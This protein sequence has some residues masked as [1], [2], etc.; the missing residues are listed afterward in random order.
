M[1]DSILFTPVRAGAVTLPNRLVMAPLT[2][3]RAL[4]GNVPN[5]LA[6][7]YY[8]QRATAGL[9]VAEATQVTPEG[10]GYPDTPGIHSDAQVEGWKSIVEAVHAAGGRIYLQLWHVGRVSHPLYQPAGALPVSASAI[11]IKGQL[12]THEGMKDYVTPRALETEEVPGVVAQ[13]ADGAAKAKRAGFDGVE[14]HAANGY[15]IDQFLRSGSNIRTDRYGG[16][17]ENRARF[18]LEVTEAVVDVWGAERVGVRFSPTG[19][20]N[21]M[22]DADPVATFGHATERLNRFGLSYLHVIEPPVDGHPMSVPPGVPRVA[23][24]LRGLFKGTFILNGG[25]TKELAEQAIAQG[26]ADAV[27]FGVPYLANPDLLER[28]RRN[29]PLNPPDRDTFYGGGAKGY[30]DYPFLDTVAAE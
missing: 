14:V 1:T 24:H 22:W 12:Y 6:A 5:P 25:F 7:T 27:A 23:D 8:A 2:R 16:S 26:R 29:A 20:G 3:S 17:V 28:F 13:Y 15:L 18:L 19:N 21:G 11:G 10:Q 9:I 4:S 30:T